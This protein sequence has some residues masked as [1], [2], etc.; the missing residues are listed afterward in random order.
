MNHTPTRSAAY[1]F[2][3]RTM[4]AIQVE[5]LTV[6]YGEQPVLWD[7]DWQVRTGVLS[8]IVGPNGAGKSTLIKAIL[9]LVRP[10]AG[11]VRIQNQPLRDSRRKIAYVPQ[12]NSVDWDFPTTVFD[13]VLMGTY[14]QLGWFRRPGKQQR[15]A[16]WDTLRQVGMEEFAKR[17][18]RELSG[19]QQQRTFLARAL[20][21]QAPILL[22]DEPFQGID[23][24]TEQ[25]LVENL[26]RLRNEGR[27]VVVVHHDLATVAEYF[28]EVLLLNVRRI[29]A[30]P[31]AEVLT[32]ENLTRAY[33]RVPLLWGNLT[34][35][36]A[37]NEES[38]PSG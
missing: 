24:V 29:A 2:R 32:P 33:G 8:A 3:H 28:D 5:D 11:S 27:T 4:I 22:M 23:A 13:V 25:T 26:R 38:K 6:A 31:C 9:G 18:I 17:Q 21:Q 19:G 37:Q 20:V 14:G 1:P 30:G 16:A 35:R 10:V 36:A 12:R 7:I 15:Q 34:P